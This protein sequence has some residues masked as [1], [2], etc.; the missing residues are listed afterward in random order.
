[1]KCG[2]AAVFALIAAQAIEGVR[3]PVDKVVQLLI[4]LK[5]GIEHDGA[6]EQIMY[7]KYACWCEK[8]SDR[9]AKAITDASGE[10]RKLGQSILSLKGQ[11]ATL[12]SEI[13]EF[14]TKIKENE[15]AQ[16][17]A[18]A[19]RQKENEEFM[20][21]STEMKEVLNALGKA[22]VILKEGTKGLSFLQEE[23]RARA[24]VTTV[25]EALPSAAIIKP[26]TSALLREFATIKGSAKYAPQSM[27]IQG[28]LQDMFDQFS[29]DLETSTEEEGK[30]NRQFEDLIAEKMKELLEMKELMAKKEQEK[31]EAETMLADT[32][33]Q[34][35]D[36]EAQMKADIAFFDKMKEACEGKSEAWSERSTLRKAEL[37]GITKA[38]EILNSD[39]AREL[40]DKSIKPGKETHVHESLDS[41]VNTMLLQVS[42]GV[43]AP[44]QKAYA[45]LKA[46]ATKT[47]SLRLAALAAKVRE[48][49]GGNFDEVIA[50]IDKIIA[51]LKEEAVEDMKK[52]DQCLD[53]YQKI[54]STIAEVE[55]LIEK[56]EA[57]ISKLEKIIEELK[58]EMQKTIEEIEEVKQQIITI[59]QVRKE[60]NEA[61]LQAKK[62]DQD[63]IKLLVEARGFLK[64]FYEKNAIP[65]EL[66][67]QGPEFAVPEDQAPE[68][69]FS[70][71]GN[72]K[73]ESKGVVS[74]MT[75]IIQ[76]LDD[77]IKNAMKDEAAAQLEFEGQLAAAEKL[78]EDLEVK[79]INLEDMIAKNDKDLTEEKK[80][81]ENNQE[82]LKAEKDYETEIKPD[83]DW[84]IGA[85]DKR[86]TLRTAEMDGLVQAKGYLAGEATSTK[87]SLLQRTPNGNVNDGALTKIGFLGMR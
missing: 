75:M 83:C 11:L 80:D 8:T 40:F 60:E 84:I 68:A 76:D 27:T 23:S 32:T 77:E 46:S 7:D 81:L 49:T 42:S 63:A 10:L 79:K 2:W 14:T 78:Q 73:L 65:L 4:D 33:Q 13:E 87:K 86:A 39:E 3:S 41:G 45:S 59:K 67:Q 25:I 12:M 82:D 30:K 70:D 58:L 51:T 53:Q 9:K 21:E 35:D 74:I 43:G 50:A 24:A 19:I 44:A 17:E 47:H 71:K 29:G 31:A 1:M 69:T 57:K 52:R 20:A 18:T 37:E 28:I 15:A 48:A 55:W 5:T 72:R 64:E 62:D 54:A 16:A 34:Y 6:T 38:I 85:F 26:K 56:N 66:A 36:T 61:F 22:I